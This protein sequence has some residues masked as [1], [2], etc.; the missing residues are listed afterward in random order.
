MVQLQVRKPRA[1][2]FDI[3]GS[4]AKSSFIDKVLMP[5]ITEFI[6]TYLEENFEQKNVCTDIEN[7]REQ[8]KRDEAAPK[9]PGPEAGRP[10]LIDA[11]VACVTHCAECKK[12]NKAI[13]LLRFH[14]WFDGYKRERIETPVYSDVAIQIQ[15]WRCDQDIKLFV[16]SN[17]WAEATKRFLSRT[18][19]GDMNLLI[20]DHFDTT[21]GPL[22]TQATFVKVSEKVQLPA[23]DLLFLTKSADEACAAQNAGL[24]VVLVLTHR[25]NIEKLDGEARR[26]P[27]VRSF[28]ELE[29][30]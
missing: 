27:R 3:S 26:I 7:L 15:K 13:T 20:E 25:R 29:F 2:L 30:V 23:Q 28:N 19:H 21:L 5:Y 18:N 17:G 16:F 10:A 24:I 6:R 14:M 12:E 11:T 4:V 1:I 22:T 9:I 8:A